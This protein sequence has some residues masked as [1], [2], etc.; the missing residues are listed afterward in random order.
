MEECVHDR[1]QKTF[2]WKPS[3]DYQQ[4]YWEAEGR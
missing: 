3:L 4:S 2:Q 1:A